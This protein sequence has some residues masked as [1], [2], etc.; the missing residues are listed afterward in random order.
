[1]YRPPIILISVVFGIE[2]RVFA[3]FPTEEALVF[4]EDSLDGSACC[5]AGGDQCHI[6]I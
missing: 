3:D 2:S 1:M 6:L 5:N 4:M